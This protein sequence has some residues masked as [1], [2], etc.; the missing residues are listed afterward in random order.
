MRSKFIENSSPLTRRS[1]SRSSG[2]LGYLADIKRFTDGLSLFGDGSDLYAMAFLE[3]TIIQNAKDLR[4]PPFRGMRG[5]KLKQEIIYW[6]RIRKIHHLRKQNL[7]FA[8]IG[9]ILNISTTRT[10]QN[11]NYLWRTAY[12]QWEI[13]CRDY[14]G[15]EF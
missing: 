14:T 8:A 5:L 15:R 6:N 12:R 13:A 11:Y 9:R 7:T 10:L 3:A 4:R 1:Y 2:E